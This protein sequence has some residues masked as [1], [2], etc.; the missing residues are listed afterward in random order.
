MQLLAVLDL[1]VRWSRTSWIILLLSGCH[2]GCHFLQSGDF[3]PTTSRSWC[4][5]S[6]HSTVCVNRNSHVFRSVDIWGFQVESVFLTII[7]DGAHLYQP[8][9]TRLPSLLSLL[10]ITLA[11][12]ALIE[13]ACRR[14][15]ARGSDYVGSPIN[16]KLAR[17]LESQFVVRNV[18]L[19]PRNGANEM[20]S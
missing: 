3:H 4:P 18:L 5:P 17:N 16:L 14:L 20:C 11:L 15:P 13:I 10:T 19:R 8:R 1:K 2:D 6:P 12:I 9:I 7:K